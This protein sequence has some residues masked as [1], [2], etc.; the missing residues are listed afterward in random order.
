MNR[1]HASS[2]VM[3]LVLVVVGGIWLLGNLNIIPDLDWGTLWPLIPLAIGLGFHAMF[4]LRGRDAG[5]LVPGGIL[6]TYGLFWLLQNFTTWRLSGDLWGIYP[7]G[8]AIGLFELYLFGGR[9][10][11]LLWPVG[12]L[13]L[14]GFGGIASMTIS[15]GI[16]GALVL[17]AIGVS[18]IVNRLR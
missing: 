5:V 15:P 13:G 4:F 3:G 6:T 8:V 12:I 14:V 2:Y 10:P 16:I 7:L 18:M 17:I 1:Q 9:Q 11:G